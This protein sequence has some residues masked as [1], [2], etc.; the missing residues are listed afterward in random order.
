MW[1][2]NGSLCLALALNLLF[3]MPCAQVSAAGTTEERLDNV[4][5][6]SADKATLKGAVRE[7]T[8]ANGLKVIL[9]E[10][11]SFPVATTMMFY[12]VG[13]RNENLGETG[14]SHLVEH[15]LF[16]KVGRYRKGE[17]AATI[18]RNGGM[19]NG[20]TSDDF[21]VFFE[22]MS[23]SKLPLALRI[24][25][26][27]MRSASFTNDEVQAEI[28]RIDAEL[29]QEARDAANLL[30]KEVRSAA[31]QLHPYKNPTIGWRNDV[32]KLTIDD[33]KRHY[34]D[35]YQPGNA[36]LVVV[37]DFNAGQILSSV[38]K[39][40]AGIAKA[41]PPRPVRV[42]EPQQRAE[43]RV[44]MKGPGNSDTVAMAYHS[45]GF[46]ENDAPALAVLEKL[47]VSGV[48]GRL[49]KSLIDSKLCSSLKSNY[50]IKRD[51]G[52]FTV[53]MTT[54]P[55]VPAS[56]ATQAFE[57]TL[58]QVKNGQISDS[59]LRRARNHAE[60]Y[61]L[62]E[63]DGPYR[64][65]FHLGYGEIIDGWS[66]AS[67]WF[68]R[69]KGVT[70]ADIQRV[71]KRY[72]TQE[73]R[74]LGIL[75]G[76]ANKGAAVKKE[77][78]KDKETD[79][80]K[81]KAKDKD[82]DKDKNKGRSTKDGHDKNSSDKNLDK[83]HKS[84]PEKE[85][86]SK[87]K[88]LHHRRT[89]SVP[90]SAF[91]LTSCA[92]KA[93]D[94]DAGTATSRSS[95]KLAQSNGAAVSDLPASS[96]G[97]N[98]KK[99][100]LD[101]GVT[102]AV[103]ETKLSPA[104]QI[105]GA[106][107]AGEAYEPTGKR[108]AALVLAQL[109]N[110]GS[111]KYSRQTAVSV[112]DDLGILPGSMVKFESG[113]Q[114]ITFQ[115]KCLSRDAGTVLGILADQMCQ[116]QMRD[117][118]VDHAKQAVIEKIKHSEDTVKVRVGRALLQG[119]IAPNTSFYPLEPMD[120][121]NF[122]NNLKASDLR[123]FHSQAVR[124][125]AATIVFVGDISLDHAVEIC[126]SACSGWT[127][128]STAKKVLVKANP[129]RLLKSSMTLENKQDAMVTIGKLVD[130]GQG[131][132]DYPL[133][134]LADCAL[135][136]HPIISRFAQKISGELGL[137]SSLSLED[138]S[139]DT[140][141]MPGSTLWSIDIP[142][143]SNL[144][145]AAV[146]TIQA[147]LKK[148]GKSGMTNDEYSEVRLYLLNALPVRWMSNSQLVGHTVLESLVLD[149]QLDPLPALMQGIKSSSPDSVNHFIHNTFRPDRASLVIAGSRQTIGQVHGLKQGEE[150]GAD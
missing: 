16:D 116:P 113:P 79:K 58:E 76:Q 85:P 6:D 86:E 52:L 2:K 108:G 121:A 24:E 127:G 15:L 8:L 119:L 128:K 105:Y 37:G 4:S 147:E 11:H 51:P 132:A 49:R 117:Q 74:V 68:S 47:L 112:Q 143:V 106:V 9:L 28:K 72:F 70:A 118:D 12:R 3:G 73:N 145:P 57:S 103:L 114:W 56:K 83:H 32:Q 97:K 133:L 61:V 123:E 141:S 87:N 34:R 91:G 136:S 41:E 100:V 94:L 46:L 90:A 64:T 138:L 5:S 53:N 110:D 1:K 96:G 21:T 43:R 142:L 88:K 71:A 20:F 146:R 82:K 98:L 130:S 149:D 104:V 31:F 81:D 10:E 75:S 14:I 39:M 23:P 22:T 50:E 45:C 44:I 102:V 18:A 77:D 125:D 66:A 134:L 93:D 84:E 25:A 40:F 60:F 120:K 144:M 27:R 42:V 122:I 115:G 89:A 137:S 126:Q 111:Q 59:E 78:G 131:K 92:Y 48:N 29:S 99:A 62:S 17:L 19:F 38:Q 63:R 109:M 13:S 129:R 124:P 140:E 135:T 54:S 101:N 95:V 69:L 65:A 139:G 7:A 26:E 35:Y 55:G 67:N 150:A 30:N 33:V 80:A 107:K 148:F 36:V